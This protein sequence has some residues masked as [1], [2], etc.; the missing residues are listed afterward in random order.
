MLATYKK[1][2]RDH[3]EMERTLLGILSATS[4]KKRIALA[5]ATSDQVLALLDYPNYFRLMKQPLPANRT[6][7]LQRLAAETLIQE[8][9]DDLELSDGVPDHPRHAG[10]QAHQ[11]VRSGRQVKKGRKLRSY[12]GLSLA[13]SAM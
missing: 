3:P 13:C 8:A 10:I 11:A 5:A 7:I 1:K 2:L 6:A 12:L 9:G 4:F